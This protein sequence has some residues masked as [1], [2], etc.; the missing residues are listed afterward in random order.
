VWQ[1]TVNL[2]LLIFTIGW[3]GAVTMIG[4]LPLALRTARKREMEALRD[5]REIGDPSVSLNQCL[6][7]FGIHEPAVWRL[8]L[9]PSV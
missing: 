5:L 4:A 9:T 7:G 3:A 1:I 2:R 8:V 6:G